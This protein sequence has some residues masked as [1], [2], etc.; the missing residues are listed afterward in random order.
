MT[1]EAL[2]RAWQM[3]SSMWDPK[4]REKGG[5]KFAL[6]DLTD[7]QFREAARLAMSE[8]RFWPTAYDIK[9]LAPPARAA[10]QRSS[11]QP[12]GY[13]APDSMEM[14]GLTHHRRMCELWFDAIT[15]APICSPNGETIREQPYK[16]GG[17]GDLLKKTLATQYLLAKREIAD[18]ESCTTQQHDTDTDPDGV[19]R[20]LDLAGGN[21]EPLRE[22]EDRP[23]GVRC[24]S[25]GAGPD[26]GADTDDEQGTH[27]D[28]FEEDDR[29]T[30]T[31]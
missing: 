2:E 8:C 28:P 16:Q 19:A 26:A 20:V 24:D 31:A 14:G 10:L 18:R 11:T 6:K 22:K 21:V 3:W 9:R 25:G 5:Y 30:A 17:F 15:R 23:V 13:H 12:T 7:D 27:D 4:N 29:Y 1:D